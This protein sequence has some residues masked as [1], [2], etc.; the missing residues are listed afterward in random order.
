MGTEC[1]YCGEPIHAT[2]EEINNLCKS[3]KTGEPYCE[4][5][6]CEEEDS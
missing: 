6:K 2:D 1:A 3:G 5:C 4:D